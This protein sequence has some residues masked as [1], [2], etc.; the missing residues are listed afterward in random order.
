MLRRF[1]FVSET[2]QN[3]PR[4]TSEAELLPRYNQPLYLTVTW[5]KTN[6]KHWNDWKPTTTLPYYQ[7]R[8]D[9]S[10]L[11]WTRLTTLT[12]WTHLL[13]TNKLTKNLNATRRQ[14]FNVNL[15]AKY[16]RWK[17]MT[18]LKH[19]ATTDWGAQC[20]KVS[21]R[22][23]SRQ[24]QFFSELL[25]PGRSDYTNYWYSWVQTIT[26]IRE[27]KHDVTSNGKR[28]KWNFCCLSLAVL[29]SRVKIFLFAVNSRRH[30]SIFVWLIQGLQEENKKSEV[31]FAVCHLL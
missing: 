16:L 11:L 13:T 31:I 24:Q 8:K 14:H 22:N 28:Q 17:R 29:Y 10:L 6:N 12:N 18:L 26:K 2:Y 27:I 7:P 5:Q 25:S 15:T 9:V 23:V 30:L 1:C 21:C 3:L 4:I 20:Y 19:N